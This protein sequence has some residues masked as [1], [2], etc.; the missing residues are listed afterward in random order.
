VVELTH[1]DLN[2]RFDIS[3]VFIANYSFSGRRRPRRQRVALGDRLHES[4]DQI[5]SIFQRCS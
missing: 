2:P 1:T 4:Q 3:V 5:S